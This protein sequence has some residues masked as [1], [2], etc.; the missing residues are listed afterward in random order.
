MDARAYILH[1]KPWRDTSVLLEVFCRERGRLRVAARGVK[2]KRRSPI[3]GLLQAFI[4]LHLQLNASRDY[5]YLQDAEA[6]A[7]GWP[8]SP[9]IALCALY[10]NE[11]LLR[12]LP[13]QDSHPQ[14]FDDYERSLQLLALSQGDDSVIANCLRQFEWA[15]LSELGY[16]IALDCDEQGEPVRAGQCYRVDADIGIIGSAPVAGGFSGDDLL[17]FADHNWPAN[18]TEAKRLLRLLLAAHL[19][20]EPLHTRELWRARQVLKQLADEPAGA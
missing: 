12:L 17:A 2:G 16:G 8:L 20:S 13:E 11:L 1:V 10:C 14:L 19:G 3:A 7:P 6:L 15:L 5:L 4:P 9:D 18:P